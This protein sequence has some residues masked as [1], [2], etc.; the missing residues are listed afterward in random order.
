VEIA[1][2][3]QLG[4]ARVEPSIGRSTL[5]FWTMAISAGIVGDVSVAT[6]LAHVDVPAECS[7]AASFDRRHHTQLAKTQMPGARAAVCGTGGAEYIRD[8]QR[9]T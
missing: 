1:H 4:A 9:W 2:R 5:A 7:S 6:L 8:L 3:Q